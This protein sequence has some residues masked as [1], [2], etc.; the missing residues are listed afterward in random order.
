MY[1]TKMQLCRHIQ[2][3]TFFAL[4]NSCDIT[5]NICF[6]VSAAEACT[7]ALMVLLF[8]TFCN[9][10]LLCYNSSNTNMTMLCYGTNNTKANILEVA[11]ACCS[12]LSVGIL[13]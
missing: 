13:L 1:F 10:R 8:Y 9:I 4:L 7:D 11:G 3:W 2:I 6:G 5:I 12:K